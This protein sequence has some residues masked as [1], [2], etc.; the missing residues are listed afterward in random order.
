MIK[1]AAGKA[2]LASVGVCVEA[3]LGIGSS[4]VGPWGAVGA[5]RLKGACLRLGASQL[6]GGAVGGLGAL[7]VPFGGGPEGLQASPLGGKSLAGGLGGSW[8]PGYQG[9]GICLLLVAVTSG[10]A[11][12]CLP[13]FWGPLAG[14]RERGAGGCI[15]ILAPITQCECLAAPGRSV[16]LRLQYCGHPG[17]LDSCLVGCISCSPPH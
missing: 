1:E 14:R 11:P 8:V 6:R 10:L 5:L 4:C 3:T 15:L 7:P 9:F 2:E 17:V 12:C 13:L 16:P